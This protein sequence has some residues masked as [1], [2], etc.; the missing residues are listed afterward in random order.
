M[1]KI[2]QK[3]RNYG[4]AIL[5]TTSFVGYTSAQFTEDFEGGTIIP[6]GWSAINNNADAKEWEF[7]VPPSGSANSGANS[8]YIEYSSV[9]HDDYLITPA[10]TVT[11]GTSDLLKLYGK[12]RSSSFL[13]EFNILIST[14]GT[15]VADFSTTLQAAVQPPTSWTEYEYFLT[16]YVGQTIYIAFQAISQDEFGLYLDDISVSGIPT[17]PSPTSLATANITPFTADLSWTENGSAAAWNIEYGAPGFAPGSGTTV[18]VTSNPY[19]ITV[20]SA[21]TDYDFYVQSDCGGGDLSVFEGPFSFS[22]PPTCLA[23]TALTVS[24][25][26]TTT[27]DL[28]WTENGTA[29]LYNIEYGSPG[30]TAGNGT[31]VSGVAN[32]YNLTGLTADTDY[33]FYV[34]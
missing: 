2:L 20:L 33:E 4:L 8:A 7:G 17:C 13:E 18:A 25:L 22:T 9:A 29:S 32:P 1:K 11:A 30:F 14:T 16:S 6:A 3:L 26:T 15:A 27:A 21:E 5:A 24:N 34:Q 28:S 23:P 12:N 19:N 31:T 10:I